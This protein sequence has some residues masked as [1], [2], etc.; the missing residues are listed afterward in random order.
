MFLCATQLT[1]AGLT[2]LKGLQKLCFVM[3]YHALPLDDRS[4]E[5][6]NAALIGRPD[7]MAGRTSLTVYEGMIGIRRTS[8]STPT[9]ARKPSPR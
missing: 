7:L 5:Q 9:T 3:G 1:D 4:V 8:S 2:N 6:F